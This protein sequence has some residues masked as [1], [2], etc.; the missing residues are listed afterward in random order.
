MRKP[1]QSSNA[2]NL[3]EVADWGRLFLGYV[4]L[5]KQEKVTSCRSATVE[6]A[7]DFARKFEKP[8]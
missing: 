2:G 8:R 6:V 5:A 3:E 1:D 7:F 4:F